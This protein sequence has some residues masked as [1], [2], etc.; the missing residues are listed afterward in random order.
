MNTISGLVNVK[1]HSFSKDLLEKNTFFL[2]KIKALA[3]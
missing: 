1:I 3:I 2:I